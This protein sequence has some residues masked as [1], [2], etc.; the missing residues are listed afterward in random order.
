MAHTSLTVRGV[1]LITAVA[2]VLTVTVFPF[3]GADHSSA[4]A[5]NVSMASS[6]QCGE[7]AHCQMAFDCGGVCA[8]A[9]HSQPDLQARGVGDGAEEQDQLVALDSALLTLLKPP[10]RLV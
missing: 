8:A 2:L 5:S 1:A 3:I 4:N 10:P 9:I 6:D 7:V